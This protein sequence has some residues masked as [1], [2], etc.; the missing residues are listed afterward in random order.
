MKLALFV[1][2]ILFVTTAISSRADAQ[3]YPWCVLWSGKAGGSRNCGF[4]SFD[5]CMQTAQGAGGFCMQNTQYEPP[6][7]AP[8]LRPQ[9][10]HK[11]NK[12]QT[13]KYS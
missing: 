1:L 5:Q 10:R 8:H 4:V 12:H 7:A 2:G 11:A 6:A 9:V 3:N 13:D